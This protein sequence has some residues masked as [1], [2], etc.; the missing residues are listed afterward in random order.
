MFL[1]KKSKSPLNHEDRADGVEP[2]II[3]MH[4]T[5]METM[6]AARERLSDPESKVS[7]HYLVDTD[8]TLYDLVPEDKRAWH[9]GLSYWH[10]ETDI[11]SCSIGIEIVNPGHE[12]GYKP[13]PSAQMQTVME[14]GRAIKTRHDIKYV[15]GHS[16]IA[17]E[18]KKDPG[19]L[20]PWEW[21]AGQG[22]G[23]WPR[24]MAE[25]IKMAEEIAC[26]DYQVE[27]LFT[28]LG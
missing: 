25:D 13:F 18:R 26:N 15:L 10:G 1:K 9:A 8:G 22:V 3:I 21:L 20:F 28:Q 12:F 19:E 7:A 11:N 5:G 2:S 14:L 16:D 27:R 24:P 4:Y 23:M 17:P 6:L